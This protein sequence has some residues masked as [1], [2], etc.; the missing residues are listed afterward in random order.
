MNDPARGITVNVGTVG[1][2][3]RSNVIAP[4]SHAEVD[5]RVPT[6]EDARR[7]E[8][9]IRGLRPATGGVELSVSGGIERPPMEKSPGSRSLWELCRRLGGEFGLDLEEGTAGG[10]S[11]GNFTSQFC[12]TLDGLGPV[13]HGAHAHHEHILI[14]ETLR[15]AELLTLLVVSPPTAGVQSH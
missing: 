11:D 9:A 2:G 13:G 5:V 7:V 12:P 10:A 14:D 1:G 6:L 8:T 15:R 3:L 4:D